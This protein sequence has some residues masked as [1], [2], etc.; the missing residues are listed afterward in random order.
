MAG[1]RAA[2]EGCWGVSNQASSNCDREHVDEPSMEQLF[3]SAPDPAACLGALENQVLG[4]AAASHDN[5]SD[6][7]VAFH[8][9]SAS[10]V[11]GRTLYE[12]T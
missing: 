1:K 9:P 12:A 5:Y 6:V 2:L 11:A 7:A 8:E 4:H 10:S 3:E